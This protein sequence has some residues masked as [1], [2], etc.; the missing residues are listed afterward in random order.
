M[1]RK[2]KSGNKSSLDPK[3]TSSTDSRSRLFYSHPE[4]KMIRLRALIEENKEQFGSQLPDDCL[5]ARAIAKRHGSQ[6]QYLSARKAANDETARQKGYVLQDEI[7]MLWRDK[8][9]GFERAVLDGDYKW[10]ERQAKVIRD[11]NTLSHVWFEAAVAYELEMCCHRTRTK[12][13]RDD[14]VTLETAGKRIDYTARQILN[15]FETETRPDRYGQKRFYVR[16][17]ANEE[18]GFERPGRADDVIKKIAKL[19]GYELKR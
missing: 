1:A 19:L 15:R 8:I 6:R 4:W 18:Y 17:P 13:G 14:D 5:S 3:R 2:P 16:G 12:E 11:G 9:A 7:D 10:F